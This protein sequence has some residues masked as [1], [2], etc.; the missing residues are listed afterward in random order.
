LADNIKDSIVIVTD[1][2]I[3]ENNGKIIEFV[4]EQLFT[5]EK[6]KNSYEYSQTK[7]IENKKLQHI[8]FWV[9][10]VSLSLLAL[11]KFIN[12]IIWIWTSMLY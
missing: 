12:F 7:L 9:F 6:I 8:M 5:M 1:R 3:N 10:G 4:N 11:E 2:V